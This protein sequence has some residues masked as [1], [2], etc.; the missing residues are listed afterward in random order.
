MRWSCFTISKQLSIKTLAEELGFKVQEIELSEK[1]K[2]LPIEYMPRNKC[3]SMLYLL[4]EL[5]K[6]KSESL[7]NEIVKAGGD[8]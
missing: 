6:L 1:D 8:I 5:A 7:Q 2:K 4:A 3:A